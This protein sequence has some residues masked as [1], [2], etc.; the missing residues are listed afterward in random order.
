MRF[1]L[2]LTLIFPILVFVSCS[3]GDNP[4]VPGDSDGTPPIQ[5]ISGMK[6]KSPDGG[7]QGVLGVWEIHINRETLSTE[8]IPARNAHAIGDFFDADLSQFLTVSPCSDCLWIRSIS[9]PSEDQIALAIQMRHPFSNIY[10]RPDLHGFDVRAIFLCNPAYPPDSG[11][12]FMKT[13]GTLEETMFGNYYFL[14]PDG[15]TSHFTELVNDDRY[16]VLHEPIEG[17]LFPFL[18]F[19]DSLS[20][21]DF[22]PDLPTGYNVMPVASGDTTRTAVFN[23]DVFQDD[24]LTMYV[25]ADVAFGQASTFQNRQDPE[26]Y[27]P[28]F[29]RT[30]PWRIE[31]WYENNNLDSAVPTSSADLMV[32]VFDWQ[33]DADVDPNYPDPANPD[34]IPE[35][36]SV[37]G[38]RVIFPE[39]MSGK[40]DTTMPEAGNGK[41]N[42]PLRYRIQIQNELGASGVTY[43]YVAVYDELFGA[44]SPSGRVP[45]P[46]S[47]SGFPYSTSDIRDYAFYQVIY[48]N[49]PKDSGVE[50]EFK[51]ELY[52]EPDSRFTPAGNLSLNPVFFMDRGQQ[53]FQYEWDHDYD[54]VTFNVDSS[55]LPL[56]GVSITDGRTGVGLKVTTNTIPPHEYVYQIPVYKEGVEYH[57]D[58]ISAPRSFST[59]HMRG[60]AIDVTSDKCYVAYTSKSSGRW[61]VNLMIL[62]DAGDFDSY[63]V[64]QAATADYWQPALTV[65]EDG[66]D[67][68]IYL[69]FTVLPDGGGIDLQSNYGN[70]DG[71]GFYMANLASVAN[72][73]VKFEFFPNI[74][75]YNGTL[76]CYYTDY[77]LLVN[78]VIEV[79]RST[80]R[81]L[82]WTDHAQVDNTSIWQAKQSTTINGDRIYCVWE[83]KRNDTVSMID[84]YL[85]RSIPSDFTTFEPSFGVS[86]SSGLVDDLAPEICTAGDKLFIAY[87]QRESGVTERQTHVQM[88]TTDLQAMSD[89]QIYHAPYEDHSMPSIDAVMDNRLVLS[90][91]THSI[92]DQMNSVIVYFQYVNNWSSFDQ[93]VIL[94]EDSGTVEDGGGET[95]PCVASRIALDGGAVETFVVTRNFDN[96]YTKLTSPILEYFGEIEYHNV[97]TSGER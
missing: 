22:D 32:Q 67:Q 46:E 13:D 47:P 1:F 11:F 9:F 14:N 68:G 2:Y 54:G 97:I 71:S 60:H 88:L 74:Q 79:A 50:A 37:L 80:D 85:A 73:P 92:S 30:E 33:H 51:N 86:L 96:D 82:T 52:I 43:G 45:I 69:V 56:A 17:N 93:Q 62:D 23:T 64:T 55:G 15:F 89:Y 81:A 90:F 58:F 63:K 48:A 84:L 3:G 25:I 87:L 31:Y 16:F 70:L 61:N 38:V 44:Q 78:S 77:L 7:K 66:P 94:M 19:F 91:G 26:Y 4:A 24:D 34:G 40:I 20:M 18:R 29:N 76:Y 53:M 95:Y 8:I 36:S 59:S 12:T 75:Y 65:V 41:P 72:D 39:M 49:I 35:S 57:D 28:A 10:L 5:E 42:N 27:L 21:G 83:D 6:S